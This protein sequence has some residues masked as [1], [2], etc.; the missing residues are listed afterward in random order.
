MI[1]TLNFAALK[2]LEIH[3]Y[4]QGLNDQNSSISVVYGL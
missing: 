3:A 4:W 2:L 1:I